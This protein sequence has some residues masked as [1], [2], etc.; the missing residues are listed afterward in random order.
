MMLSPFSLRVRGVAVLS[1]SWLCV[2]AMSVQSF[3]T[4]GGTGPV[5]RWST[6]DLRMADH[7]RV[8]RRDFWS[9][10][11]CVL[12]GTG[13]VAS[14][15]P[16]SAGA[17]IDVRGLSVEG[18]G[19]GNL[20]GQVKEIERNR[21]PVPTP[22]ARLQTSLAADN[23]LIPGAATNV[24]RVSSGPP[25]VR[26]TGPAGLLSVFA[27]TLVDE[28]NKF[29]N[30]NFEF[31]SDWLQLDRV[32]G[33]IQYVDQ[34]NGDKL[35]VLRAPAPPTTT[36]TTEDGSTTTSTPIPK[37]WYGDVLF[38]PTDG[39]IARSGNVVDE[40]RVSSATT[41]PQ[42][43]SR[44]SRA[45]SVDTRRLTVKYATVTGNGYRVERRALVSATEINGTVYMMVTSSNAV[46]FD[47]KGKERDTVESIIDSF[48]IQ[49]A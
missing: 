44:G 33:G 37:A 30:V 32:L 40:Y 10:G 23:V 1:L 6:S 28:N 45:V 36:T 14:S 16:Q 12:G 2:M 5:R 11:V 42:I 25:V 38:N 24:K 3:T 13:V 4:S 15:L 29:V 27:D 18:G 43:Q 46:K 19:A 48:R 49:E 26:R 41:V 21:E 35:Y 8:T 22:L 17:G 39:A 9:T 47:A 20:A 34:R 7:D 31:P